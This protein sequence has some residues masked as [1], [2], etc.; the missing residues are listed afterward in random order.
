MD[1]F[2]IVFLGQSE[3]SGLR[4]DIRAVLLLLYFLPILINYLL[5]AICYSKKV[6][7]KTCMQNDKQFEKIQ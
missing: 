6:G 2:F 1:D 7:P 5:R 4:P 3:H